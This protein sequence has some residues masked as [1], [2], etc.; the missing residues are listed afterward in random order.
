MRFLVSGSSPLVG[1]PFPIYETNTRKET[2]LQ[3]VTGSVLTALRPFSPMR[4]HI[5]ACV[6]PSI[7]RGSA[8]P[9]NGQKPTVEYGGSESCGFEPR[10]SPPTC[11]K[12]WR[13]I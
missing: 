13:I 4:L 1:S 7:Y 5:N 8:T 10:R 2:N 3:T 9:G 12:A 6:V 11:S